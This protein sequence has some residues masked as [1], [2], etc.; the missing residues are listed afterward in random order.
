M[1]VVVV[2]GGWSGCAIHYKL[3]QISTICNMN[4]Q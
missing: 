2:G 1:K 4:I 3:Q